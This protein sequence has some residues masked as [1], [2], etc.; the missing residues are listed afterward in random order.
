MGKPDAKTHA[1]KKAKQRAS[2]RSSQHIEP[3][4]PVEVIIICLFN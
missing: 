3:N 4:Y 2:R 1:R